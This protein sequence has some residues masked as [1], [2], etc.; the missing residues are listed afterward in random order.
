MK[1]IFWPNNGYY[2]SFSLMLTT[3][4]FTL[5][6][7][8]FEMP[9]PP[10][11]IF[12]GVICIAY[13]FSQRIV[14]D[15]K[16]VRGPSAYGKRRN[17]TTIPINEAEAFYENRKWGNGYLVI[18]HKTSSRQIYAPLYF[19]SKGTINKL[20][21]IFPNQSTNPESIKEPFT[22]DLE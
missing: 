11:V 5:Y 7:K 21:E 17:R 2:I 6:F 9:M 10:Y 12:I 13:F 1:K 4:V 3:G 20:M 14:V 8:Q 18:R 15:D 19:F 16:T 22:D